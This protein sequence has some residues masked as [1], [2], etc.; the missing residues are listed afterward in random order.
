MA[1]HPNTDLRLA[2]V[3]RFRSLSV[4]SSRQAGLPPVDI[5]VWWITWRL[6]G[7]V[8]KANRANFIICV[9]QPAYTR[10]SIVEAPDV[11]NDPCFF[12]VTLVDLRTPALRLS[13]FTKG[14]DGMLVSIPGGGAVKGIANAVRL[15]VVPAG[16]SPF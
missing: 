9:S 7:L 2:L 6:A 10:G 12:V 8:R 16:A 1:T 11:D 13:G 15:P 3:P 14:V 5:H 4:V